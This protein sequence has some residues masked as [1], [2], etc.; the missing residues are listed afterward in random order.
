M[1]VRLKPEIKGK[2]SFKLPEIK[3]FSLDNGLRVLFVEKKNLP[4]VHLNLVTLGGSK[5]DP[6]NK[7]GLS[8]LTS[9]LIDEGAGE[10]SA[11]EI[12]EKMESLGTVFSSSVNQE[13]NNLTLLTLKENLDA[14]LDIY[15]K[16]ISSPRFERIDFEREKQ[17]HLTKILQLK[18]EP[19]YIAGIVFD[20]Q[21]FGSL[22]YAFP[23]IGYVSDIERIN[24]ND[25]I[26]FY[27]QTINPGNSVLIVVGNISEKELSN[28][29]NS[30][31]GN[32]KYEK[33]DFDFPSDASKK[34]SKIYLVHKDDAVQSELRIGH[35]TSGRKTADFFDKSVLNLILG[36]Q[37]SSRINLN[38]R[39]NKGYTYGV[40][41]SFDYK[42]EIGCFEVSTAVQSENTLPAIREIMKEIE[43]VRKS[44]T[45]EEVEFA[46]SYLIKR[47]P[48][49]FETYSQ[50]SRNISSLFIY[51]LADNYFDDY[52]QNIEKTEVTSVLKAAQNNLFPDKCDIVIVGNKNIIGPEVKKLNEFELEMIELPE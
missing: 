5:L 46:K 14:S 19:S 23:T 15:S 7:K 44:V 26:S 1:T 12:D 45:E 9:R 29:L 50:I 6:E 27:K 13:V 32:W 24:N 30:Y 10:Y 4:I 51:S 35:L 42:K 39:E 16:I 47:F 11:L 3:R 40:S 8:Y 17:K 20:K 36:G 33:S 52:I 22:P 21:I 38:L 28:M 18:D 41:S 34:Q 37:F 2:I 48:A 31:F 43:G 49:Q 25:V